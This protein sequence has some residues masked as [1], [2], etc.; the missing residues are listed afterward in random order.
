MVWRRCA[1]DPM[2]S[3][4]SAEKRQKSEGLDRDHGG[5]SWRVDWE[6]RV[7]SAAR[8]PDH[9]VSGR[10][11]EKGSCVIHFSLARNGAART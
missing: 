8:Q 7:Y 9:N 11:G 1:D 5:G 6:E 3:E 10:E 2:K 4:T